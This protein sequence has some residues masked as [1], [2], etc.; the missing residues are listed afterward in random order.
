MKR[1]EYC[2][3][4]LLLTNGMDEVFIETYY[5]APSEK[6]PLRLRFYCKHDTGMDY[7][8]KH[9]GDCNKVIN[10]RILEDGE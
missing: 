10:L 1:I 7:I 8:K 6:G 2:F 3:V 9:F 4:Y 5:P